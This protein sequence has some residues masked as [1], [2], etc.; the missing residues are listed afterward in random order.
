VRFSSSL[1]RST[2]ECTSNTKAGVGVHVPCALQAQGARAVDWAM[3]GRSVVRLAW[4][5]RRGAETKVNE[6]E[7]GNGWM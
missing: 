4:M 2:G 1:Q 6:E 7:E 3:D 5:E